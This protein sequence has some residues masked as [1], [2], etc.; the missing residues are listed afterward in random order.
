MGL[1]VCIFIY[2]FS[3]GDSG[4]GLLEVTMSRRSGDCLASVL[5]FE[6]VFLGESSYNETSS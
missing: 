4:L 5:D 2:R 1:L 6:F 3:L